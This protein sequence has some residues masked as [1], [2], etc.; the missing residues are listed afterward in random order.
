MQAGEDLGIVRAGGLPGLE[1]LSGKM[2]RSG[3]QRVALFGL[4]AIDD[5]IEQLVNET[6][7]EMALQLAGACCQHR[8]RVGRDCCACRPQQPRLADPRGPLDDHQAAGSRPRGLPLALDRG[9]L[10]VALV[11]SSDVLPS[12]G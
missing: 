4:R 12:T 7:W 10:D 6:E 2:R 8:H 11:Q 3:E 5:R 1:Q 9:E